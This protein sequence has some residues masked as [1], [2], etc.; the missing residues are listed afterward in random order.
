M[1]S[2]PRS[3]FRYLFIIRNGN[4][5]MHVSTLTRGLIEEGHT[6]YCVSR[7]HYFPLLLMRSWA[8]GCS[9]EGCCCDN[10]ICDNW[11]SCRWCTNNTCVHLIIWYSFFLENSLLLSRRRCLLIWI[12]LSIWEILILVI[13]RYY[14]CRLLCKQLPDSCA[15][16]SL[17]FRLSNGRII[18]PWTDG[19]PLRYL[20]ACVILIS[21]CP[22]LLT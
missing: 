13:S 21:T 11:L 7:C 18:F 1:S 10:R 3:N 19:L 12:L 2:L 8:R 14:C 20:P 4:K 22:L 6:V 17:G 5:W 9:E 15:S 16:R